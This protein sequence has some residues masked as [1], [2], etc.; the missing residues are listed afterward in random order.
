MDKKILL[1]GAAALVLGVSMYSAS[2]S[3]SALS[4]TIEGEGAVTATM[5]DTCAAQAA[6]A[7]ANDGVAHA[8]VLGLS[9]TAAQ[10]AESEE[11]AGDGQPDQ[12][13]DL[14][15]AVTGGTSVIVADESADGDVTFVAD[16]CGGAS[17]DNPV[18]GVETS[19]EWSAAGT[20]AN[21]LEVTIKDGNEVELGGAFGTI[22]F[23]DG[24]DSGVKAAFVG[25]DGDIDVAGS[26][27]GGHN[28]STSGTAGVGLLWQAPSVGGVDLFVSYSP[29]SA[30]S[31]LDSA[32]YQDT[33]GLGASFTADALSVSLGFEQSEPETSTC[34]A[35]NVTINLAAAQTAA[36]L[37]D[38]VYGTD[39]CGD[40]Q[41]MVVGA[42]MDVGDL[43]I[44][45]GYSELDSDEADRTTT[46]VDVSTSL[47]DWSLNLGYV[48]ALKK[49][50]YAGADT[51]Q[52]VIGGSIATDL[53]DGVE[54]SIAFSSNEY[55]DFSQAEGNGVTTDSRAE[56]K[57]DISF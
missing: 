51:E 11:G 2:A 9:Y 17:A 27:F 8:A 44:A 5:S 4:L 32:T 23:A 53:G 20:L 40:E 42:A 35:D 39:V 14:I 54:L 46:N 33:I 30:N 50:K 52:T 43:S 38:A 47:A 24:V 1:S 28:L 6:A 22:T 48:N 36:A 18:W 56:A 13:E 26:G 37:V 41:L 45:V 7:S 12:I 10:D 55:D 19:W 31:G 34:H 16:P 49:S 29:N 25:E 3:A 15:D 57:L 21:G